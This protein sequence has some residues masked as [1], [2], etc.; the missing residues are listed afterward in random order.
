MDE[1][2]LVKYLKSECTENQCAEVEEWCQLS[3]E[4]RKTLERIYYILFVD[5]CVQANKNADTE[6]LLARLKKDSQLRTKQYDISKL[7]RF[8]GRYGWKVA[9]FI[10]GIVFASLVIFSM[11]DSTTK[12]E[13][14]TLTDQRSK[15]VL[16][17]G[18]QIWLNSNSRIIYTSS[19]WNS[20]RKVKLEGEAYFEV[21]HDDNSPFLV[22]TK[23]IVTRVLGTKFNIRSR[24]NE[25]NVTTTLL[26]GSVIMQTPRNVNDVLLKPGQ[27]VEMNASTY[28]YSLVNYSNPNNVLLWINGRLEFNNTTLQK[29]TNILECLN[30]VKIVFIDD[31]LK[32]E[33]FTANF[34]TDDSAEKIIS[35]LSQTNR[36]TFKKEGKNIIISRN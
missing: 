17:D 14:A 2:L 25:E 4:N 24:I 18:S 9:A 12:F 16:P 8:M 22:N 7:H 33:K 6:N 11:F 1:S 32:R 20:N 28:K 23:G 15:I 19:I 10:T 29:I 35:V 26:Q 5:R 30:D 34:D 27:T 3:P 31:S 36:F 21:F 13:A